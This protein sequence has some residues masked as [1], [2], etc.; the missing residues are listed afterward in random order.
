VKSH[1]PICFQ[2]LSRLLLLVVTTRACWS[3]DV[4]RISLPDDATAEAALKVVSEVYKSEYEIAKSSD[5]KLALAKKILQTATET[6]SD[7]VGRY[8]ALRVAK[9]IATKE[10]N[11]EVAFAAIDRLAAEY[12]VDQISLRAAAITDGAKIPRSQSELEIFC[13]KVGLVIEQCV[14]ADRYDLARTLGEVAL[15]SSR[16]SK[17]AELTR[18]VVIRNKEVVQIE[19]EFVSI[20]AP[21]KALDENPTDPEANTKVG[22]FRCFIKGDWAVGTTFLALG[23]DESFKALAAAELS[24]T[25]NAMTL[26]DDW[27]ELADDSEGI[28]ERQVKL[29]AVEWYRKAL[30]VLDGLARAKVESRIH[31]VIAK[32]ASSDSSTKATSAADLSRVNLTGTWRSVATNNFFYIRDSENG[33]TVELQSGT[34]LESFH[35]VLFR[36]DNRLT[37]GR[38]ECVYKI[39]S[40]KRARQGS[41]KGTISR[42]NRIVAKITK[43]D[44]DKDG[45]I[46]ST[47]EGRTV[48]IKKAN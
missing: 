10:G 13:Q 14:Q 26:G 19:H 43:F 27:W 42:A 20:R 23:D 40:S 1:S 21:L 48:W 16:K 33:I 36:E 15:S 25:P 34:N 35:G 29:H 5:Q 4:R 37:S 45:N 17:N 18:S 47:S 41:F 8:V 22:A 28:T 12:E 9:D 44:F 30:P 38:W 24:E 3:Q 11:L 2:A 6:K 31:S 46:T 7:P 39:D 32:E